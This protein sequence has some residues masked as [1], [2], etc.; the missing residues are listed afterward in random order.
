[1][2]AEDRKFRD[3]DDR[4][5]HVVWHNQVNGP[6]WWQVTRDDGKHVTVPFT[7]DAGIEIERPE[8]ER[9]ALEKFRERK[10]E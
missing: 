6:T 4:E 3:D 9:I 10:A 7:D 8:V 5:Y 1:M 2:T